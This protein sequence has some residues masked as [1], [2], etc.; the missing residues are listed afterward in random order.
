[1][2]KKL[3]ICLSLCHQVYSSLFF[4]ELKVVDKRGNGLGVENGT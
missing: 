3:I 1:M 4:F 2:K